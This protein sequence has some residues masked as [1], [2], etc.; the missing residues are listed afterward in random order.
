MPKK[1]CSRCP[2]SCDHEDEEEVRS[3]LLHYESPYDWLYDNVISQSHGIQVIFHNAEFYQSK[4]YEC[5]QCDNGIC[6]HGTLNQFEDNN[7]GNYWLP[8]LSY[9]RNHKIKRGKKCTPKN[10][11]YGLKHRFGKVELKYWGCDNDDYPFCDEDKIY[12]R[13]LYPYFIEF[14]ENTY[15]FNSADYTL[16]SPPLGQKIRRFK[17]YFNIPPI[18]EQNGSG[19]KIYI[20]RN[21][22][23][24]IKLPNG[25]CRFISKN[26]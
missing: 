12:L 10:C 13:L 24:Y 26:Y 3:S 18:Y 19:Y 21:G 1:K 8:H 4:D 20:A 25:Q 16:D 7:G 5:W 23:H 2:V 15:G 6:I 17:R 11:H 9:S 22:A 14:L